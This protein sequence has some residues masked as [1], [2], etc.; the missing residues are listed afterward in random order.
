MKFG[1][2]MFPTDYAIRVDDLAREAEARGFESLFF[3]EHTHIPASRVTPW[4]GGAELPKE[5]WHTHDPFVA[6]A[7]A[8]TATKTL[9]VGTGICLIIERDIITLAKEVASLDFLSNGRFIFGIGGGWNVEEMG[10]HGTEFKTRWKK[11]REQVTALKR[12]WSEDAAEFHGEFVDFDPIWSWPKP[13]QKPHP[14]ILLGGHSPQVMQRV[15]DYCDGW[16]PIGLLAPKLI[17]DIATLRAK[18]EQSGRDPKTIS[19]TVFGTPPDHEAI[20]LYSEAGVERITFGLPPAPRDV[21]L[22]IL[23]RYTKLVR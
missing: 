17:Q 10:N 5:Y 14:P 20:A 16:M 2:M 3:P 6:L 15:V 19:I 11:M 18:A 9:K 12:I 13:V 8:A 1:L 21:V 23:D 4:P 22:P 7:V